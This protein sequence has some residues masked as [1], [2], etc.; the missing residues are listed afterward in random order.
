MIGG[1]FSSVY[2]T[3]N[4][5]IL[6]CN[7]PSG[8]KYEAAIRTGLSV[9]NEEW[10]KDCLIQRQRLPVDNYLVGDS[11]TSAYHDFMNYD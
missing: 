4:H 6:V 2:A 8:A 3:K 11:L 7:K 5:P 1:T 10:L 9:V